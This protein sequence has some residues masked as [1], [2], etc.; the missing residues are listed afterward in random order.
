MKRTR[1]YISK[2]EKQEITKL[3]T[4]GESSQVIANNFGIK[5]QTVTRFLIRQGISRPHNGREVEDLVE[6]YLNNKKIKYTRLVSDAPYDFDVNGLRVDVKSSNLNLKR[7]WYYYEF[8]LKDR[9]STS[10]IISDTSDFVWLYFINL[11]KLFSLR[12]DLISP[13]KSLSFPSDITKSKYYDSLN[14][15][16]YI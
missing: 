14:F 13:R 1:R 3:Y 12:S 16:T 2:Q 7:K 6:N 5:L 9:R 10:K 8:S 15:I 4:A 11:K